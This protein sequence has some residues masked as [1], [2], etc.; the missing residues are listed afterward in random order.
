M[1]ELPASALPELDWLAGTWR[2]TLERAPRGGAPAPTIVVEE[3]WLPG[4]GAALFGVN[5]AI[6]DDGRVRFE[7]LRIERCDQGGIA[8]IAMPGGGPATAFMLR[9][10]AEANGRGAGR[11]GP[12]GSVEGHAIFENPEHD[13]PTRIEYRRSGETLVATIS[14][15]VEGRSVARSWT[16]RLVPPSER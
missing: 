12:P 2:G 8:Y 7:F 16:W 1:A 10:P 13:F 14:G 3:T 4:S 9:S 11:D 6:G 15:E 5:R